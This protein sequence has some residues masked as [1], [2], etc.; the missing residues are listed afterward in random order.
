MTNILVVDDCEEFRE[1]VSD[2]LR[3][4]G[5]TVFL[6]ACPDE[7]Y[8]HCEA[9][10]MDVILCDLVM[11]IDLESHFEQDEGSAMVGV[12]AINGF[13]EKYPDTPIIAMSGQMDDAPLKG[14]K[15][16]GAAGSLAKPFGR[17]ELVRVVEKALS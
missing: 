10:K 6:A 5:Y 12:H 3:D 17:D 13:A 4:S 1:V 16:F 9:G 8:K 14:M 7:G 11:P 2:L 15:S